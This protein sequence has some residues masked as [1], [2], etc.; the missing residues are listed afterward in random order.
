MTEF[1]LNY[2]LSL[3]SITIFPVEDEID[4]NTERFFRHE[5]KNIYLPKKLG[6][7]STNLYRW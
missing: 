6:T 1:I 3:S 5:S 7:T 4:S 2:L